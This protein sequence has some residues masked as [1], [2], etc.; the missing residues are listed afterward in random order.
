ML[1]VCVFIIVDVCVMY[2][3]L[4]IVDV[5]VICVCLSIIVDVCVIC[6]CVKHNVT[7]YY[8]LFSRCFYPKR[9]TKRSFHHW[10]A[11]LEKLHSRDKREPFARLAG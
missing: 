8:I 9:H 5:C 6:V 11:E 10:G 2:V 1:C 7:L 4:S 3:C